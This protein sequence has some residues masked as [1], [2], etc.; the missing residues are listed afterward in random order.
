MA[1]KWLSKDSL[2]HRRP[3]CR[4][5]RNHCTNSDMRI[6]IESQSGQSVHLL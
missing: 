2:L 3:V 6:I 1:F 4:K 5:Q